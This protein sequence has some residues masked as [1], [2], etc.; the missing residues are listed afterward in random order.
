MMLGK[1][2]PV[3]SSTFE[4]YRRKFA[5]LGKAAAP[6]AEKMEPPKPGE[7]CALCG[8]VKRTQKEDE[9]VARALGILNLCKRAGL[10]AASTGELMRSGL[11]K[12]EVRD[13]AKLDAP[14]LRNALL[15]RATDGIW[16]DV[17]AK[18]NEAFATPCA[19]K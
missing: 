4:F 14:D 13:L 5:L 3:M 10:S 7:K 9:V 15:A 16:A 11:T 18:Q 17:I 19:L 2:M 6:K 12:T 8:Q 1:V